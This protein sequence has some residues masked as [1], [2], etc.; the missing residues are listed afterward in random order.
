MYFSDNDN[1][2]C[3]LFAI[4]NHLSGVIIN[5]SSHLLLGNT[6][7]LSYVTHGSLDNWENGN[8]SSNTS[9]WKFCCL[10]LFIDSRSHHGSQRKKNDCREMCHSNVCCYGKPIGWSMGV[11]SP[12]IILFISLSVFSIN[13]KKVCTAPNL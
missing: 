11:T 3:L 13:C 4:L 1:S 9:H 2:I 5:V 12:W 10:F 7:H 6:V 8:L